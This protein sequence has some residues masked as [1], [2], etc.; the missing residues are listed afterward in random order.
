MADAAEEPP[1]TAPPAVDTVDR[2]AQVVAAVT[3]LADWKGSS[4]QALAK[5]YK[6]ELKIDDKNKTLNA[7]L[8]EA[9]AQEARLQRSLMCCSHHCVPLT[10]AHI[11]GSYVQSDG[12]AAH[13]AAAGHRRCAGNDYAAGRCVEPCGGKARHA[14][15]VVRWDAL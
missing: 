14:R 10:E 15:G 11:D 1:S 9:V 7:A 12:R 5:F 4:R 3:K 13:P 2:V 6:I 8:K